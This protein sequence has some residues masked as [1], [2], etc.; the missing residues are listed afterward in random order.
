MNDIKFVEKQEREA[1]LCFAGTEICMLCGHCLPNE[2]EDLEAGARDNYVRDAF[3]W[4][5]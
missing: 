1:N 2:E 5:R 4:G 3:D